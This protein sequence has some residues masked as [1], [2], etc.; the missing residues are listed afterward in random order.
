MTD[1]SLFGI[2]ST[3]IGDLDGDGVVD[4][5]VGAARDEDGGVNRGAVY[6]LFL[7]ADGT[8][9]SQQKISD[10]E[11]GLSTTLANS[12]EFGRSVA[13][14][15]DIDGDGVVDIGVAAYLDDDGAT[16]SGSIYI[17]FL[18]PDG[19]VKSEQ[20]ISNTN[21]GFGGELDSIDLFGISIEELGD[22]DG[23]GIGDIAVGA[24]RD[25]DGGT[26]R[27]AVYVLFL[28]ADGTVKSEQKIS[29]TE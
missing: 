8:V 20:K 27:G 19:T 4:I 25:D 17:L 1:A 28:N 5:V 6:V 22:L 12:D 23:D 3:Q 11:G 16:A 7:N 13:N 10:I 9:K 18:K 29:D 2:S 14:I 21:G 26:D 15:G 24:L